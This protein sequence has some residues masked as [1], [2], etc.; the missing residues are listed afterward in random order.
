MVSKQGASSRLLISAIDAA[1]DGAVVA[2]L[3]DG[4][5][6]YF[7]R[8]CRH[9]AYIRGVSCRV[10]F[11][12]VNKVSDNWRQRDGYDIAGAAGA[13]G[14]VWFRRLEVRELP[15]LRLKFKRHR[16]IVDHRLAEQ[17]T[18]KAA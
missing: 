12:D 15:A 6:E 18:R 8:L 3:H 1:R 4:E 13:G 2:F 7:R 11:N 9:L 14:E 10:S 5:T 17:S 16:I